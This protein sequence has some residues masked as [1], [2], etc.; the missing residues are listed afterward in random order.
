MSNKI[1]TLDD[2]LFGYEMEKLEESR[3]SVQADMEA[4]NK[5][6][7]EQKQAQMLE[8]ERKRE[9]HDKFWSERQDPETDDDGD[10]SDDE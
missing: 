3:K 9:E 1:G 10:E 2:V 5:L 8:E 6:T 4:W 7:P